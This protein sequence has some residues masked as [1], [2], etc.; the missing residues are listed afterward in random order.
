MVGKGAPDATR[1]YDKGGDRS[2]WN[3]EEIAV[4]NQSAATRFLESFGHVLFSL[5]AACAVDHASALRLPHF[6]AKEIQQYLPRVHGYRNVVSAP[7][8]AVKN[9]WSA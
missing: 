3:C 8:D 9:H 4:F 6:V 1:F 7:H 5:R 2:D